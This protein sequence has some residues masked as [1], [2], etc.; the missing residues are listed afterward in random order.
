MML[1][2]RPYQGEALR[3]LD[4]HLMTKDTN[5]CVVI[6]TGGG[7]SILMAWAI[8]KWKQDYPAL[9]VVILAHR[10][11]LVEQNSEELKGLELFGDIGIY[12]AGLK[13]RDTE[14]SIIYASILI[15]Y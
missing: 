11:E 6:P 1:Q 12:A 3:F 13:K 9:R 4:E 14:N 8:Q 15:L 7:K 2:P 5:P 10:K